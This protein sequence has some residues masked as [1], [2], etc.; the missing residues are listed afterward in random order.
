M[1][2]MNNFH[3]ICERKATRKRRS[4]ERIKMTRY[5]R[6]VKVASPRFTGYHEQLPKGVSHFAP[7]TSVPYHDFSRRTGETTICPS[8]ALLRS[9]IKNE[10][11]RHT[12]GNRIRRCDLK[13]RHCDRGSCSCSSSSSRGSYDRLRL[14]R[15]ARCENSIKISIYRS[16][17]FAKRFSADSP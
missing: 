11:I 10:N 7:K 6:F 5:S 15:C 14:L 9:P 17:C 13:R 1:C 8:I 4:T 12:D 2:G 3:A 16:Y